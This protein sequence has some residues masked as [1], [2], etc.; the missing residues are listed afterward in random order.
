MIKLRRAKHVARRQA[1]C[2]E[3]NPGFFDQP[4]TAITTG[5]KIGQRVGWIIAKRLGPVGIQLDQNF[6]NPTSQR[7]MCAL[8]DQQF[9]A[10]NVALQEVNAAEAG[11]ISVKVN[12]RDALAANSGGRLLASTRLN[13]QRSLSGIRLRKRD[14]NFLGA[15][16]ERLLRQEVISKARLHRHSCL[17][18]FKIGFNQLEGMDRPVR[19]DQIR[20]E[21]RKSPDIRT[22]FNHRVPAANLVE[23]TTFFPVLAPQQIKRCSIEKR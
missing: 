16:A 20:K 1:I 4:E 5:T 2:S 19:T 15:F 6:R 7:L 13:S 11:R 17:Q 18:L 23:V 12:L 10:F 22:R 14:V 8:E 3:W 21:K 9:C